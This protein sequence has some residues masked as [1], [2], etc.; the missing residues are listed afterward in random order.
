MPINAKLNIFQVPLEPS[1]PF[2]SLVKMV[3][4]D[5]ITLEKMKPQ[6]LSFKINTLSDTFNQNTSISDK[7]SE[8]LQIQAVD[9]ND[10][11]KPHFEKYC[12]FC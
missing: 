10:T 7:L 6:Q 8:T 12:S 3:D 9:P 5:D 2:H 11:S 4:S 1:I